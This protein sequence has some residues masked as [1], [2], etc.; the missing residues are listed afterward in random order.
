MTIIELKKI[1]ETIQ[2]QRLEN[3]TKD[4]K[5]YFLDELNFFTCSPDP[6]RV[7]R[8]QK[9]ILIALCIND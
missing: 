8:L 2:L 3:L 7:L 5:I 9:L 4:F 6:L 1:L